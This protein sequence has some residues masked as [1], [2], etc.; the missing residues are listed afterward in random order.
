MNEQE[1]RRRVVDEAE[2]WVGTPYVSNGLIKGRRGGTDCAM[3]LV[4]V[5]G[6]VGLI[7]KE[8]DPRPYPAEWH[9]HRNEEKYMEQVLR[10]AM[11]VP[12]P[13]EREPLPADL[14]MFKVGRVFAH[15]AIIVKWPNVI[16]A[17]GGDKVG[18]ADISKDV[19][20][21]RALWM[22]PKTFFTPRS[23]SVG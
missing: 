2:S 15:A 1:M 7:P 18:H 13:P 9:V 4:G 21:K 11:E 3:I 8:Y 16:H 19:T 22:I 10:W 17:V 23:W 5:Y 12:G 14:V 6:N 20:G